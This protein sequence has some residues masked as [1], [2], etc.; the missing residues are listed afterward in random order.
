MGTYEE[1][2]SSSP[3]FAGLL[4][5]MNQYEQEHKQASDEQ[6]NHVLKQQ[7]VTH[8]DNL[9]INNENDLK[10]LP[11]YIETKQ[12]GIIQ[13]SVYVA[14]LRASIGIILGFIVFFII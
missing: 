14:Y 11:T 6:T 3:S 8:E 9:E 4:E 12:E 5:N 1:L 7:I 13:W 2:M 10:T